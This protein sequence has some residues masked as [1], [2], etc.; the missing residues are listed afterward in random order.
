MG[1]DTMSVTR[2]KV[3]R[4]VV[5][6]AARYPFFQLFKVHKWLTVAV[7]VLTGVA[8]AYSAWW[9]AH[10]TGDSGVPGNLVST[11]I[12]VVLLGLIAA[13]LLIWKTLAS[14]DAPRINRSGRHMT[15]FRVFPI[16]P[17]AKVTIRFDRDDFYEVPKILATCLNSMEIDRTDFYYVAAGSLDLPKLTLKTMALSETGDDVEL[18]L[19]SASYYDIFYTHNSPDL[20]LST[21]QATER[22]QKVTLRELFG[23]SL[24]RYYRKQELHL[25]KEGKLT[26]SPLL[27]NP[28]GVS[29]IV[30]GECGGRS[31]VLMR[32]RRNDEIAEK[33]MLEWSFAG[34][35]ESTDWFHH[36]KIPFHKFAEAEFLDEIPDSVIT[37]VG[38]YYRF[39]PIGV[40]LSALVLYQPEFFVTVRC[41]FA[42]PS[43]ALRDPESKTGYFKWI[44][45]EELEGL[46]RDE[47][48]CK[49]LC[50]PGLDLL[51][52]AR[53]EL[54]V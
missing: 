24:S 9:I 45:I 26:L 37:E 4:A 28:I 19:G 13:A 20:V 6:I 51:R 43:F 25:R 5:A 36:S 18:T 32:R 27:P 21:Q 31:W 54:F 7:W 38:N 11:L 42:D 1:C 12:E 15:D 2:R 44:P 17:N 23:D 53:P 29:G 16:K 33:G 46:F 10:V 34:L 22:F 14:S 52:A 49:Y 48:S 50:K 30:I 47:G 8:I 35:I 40:V 41:A 3:R 39:E